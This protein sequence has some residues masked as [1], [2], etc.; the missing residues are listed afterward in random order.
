MKRFEAPSFSIPKDKRFCARCGE[1]KKQRFFSPNEDFCSPCREEMLRTRPRWYTYPML[2]AVLVLTAAALWIAAFTSA[3][4]VNVCEGRRLVKEHRLYDADGK[5]ENAQLIMSEKEERLVEKF[6]GLSSYSW[7]SAGF[8]TL[9]SRYDLMAQTDSRIEAG[10]AIE[11]D[12]D[13]GSLTSRQLKR[14]QGYIDIRG[15]FEYVSDNLSKITE[16]YEISSP[17][18]IPL[19]EMFKRLDEIGASNPSDEK[20]GYIEYYKASVAQYASG[21]FEETLPHLDKMIKL[22]P[23]EYNMY[24]NTLYEHGKDT[25]DYKKLIEECA[26]V[27]ARNR[28][29][30]D[31]YAISIKAQ[32]NS[33]DLDGAEAACEELRRYNSDCP[34][35]YALLAMCKLRRGDID[36]AAEICSLGDSANGEQISTM[37]NQLLSSKNEI[38]RQSERFFL[39]SF[40]LTMVKTA[41]AL[42]QSDYPGA[43][44][45][46]YNQGYTYAYYY[47]YITGKHDP[48]TQS[49]IDMVYISA[50]LDGDEEVMSTVKEQFGEPSEKAIR[51]AGKELTLSEVFVDGKEHLF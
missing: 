26:K 9:A 37:F 38:E 25:G 21:G 14:L 17:E 15:T 10:Y 50:R 23:D 6:P 48:I 36:G 33:G 20:S 35:Y 2:A 34:E 39:Q 1:I 49:L 30:V 18:D 28:N 4:A 19:E 32:I 12:L 5:L 11:K 24:L 47:S 13:V 41:V 42:L 29:S 40:D 7:F 16:E 31:I 51:I 43:N 8:H 27:T 44:D 46:M 45:I 3:A 22:L